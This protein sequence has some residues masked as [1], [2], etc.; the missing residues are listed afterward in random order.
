MGD[1]NTGLKKQFGVGD[2]NT[3]GADPADPDAGSDKQAQDFQAAFQQEQ[4]VI[5]GHLQYTAANAEAARH[6]PLAA[7]RDAMYAAFQSTLGKIDRKNPAKAQGSIDKVLAD[8]RA[9]TS[10]VAAFHEEAEKAKTEWESRQASYDEAVHHVE[11]LEA[12]EEPKAAALRGLM[13]GIRTQVNQRQYAQA[14]ATLDQLLP[15]LAP[16]YEEYLRQKEAKPQYE[17]QSAEQSARLDPL[18]AAQRPS[19]PMTAKAGEADTALADARAKAEARDWVAG[20]EQMQAVQTAVDALEQLTN[21]P[22]RAKFL[23]DIGTLDD[24]VQAPS[25]TA[26]HTQEADWAAIAALKEQI[27]PAGDSGDYACANSMIGQLR[28]KVDAFKTK[29]D[30]LEQQKQAYDTALAQVQ[31]RLDSASVSEQQYAKLQPMLADITSV[32]GQADASAQAEDFAAALASVNDLSTKLDALDQAK[33]EIDRQKQAYEEALAALKPRLDAASVSEPPYA[34]LQAQR[35]ELATAQTGMEAAAA[36][37]DYEQAQQQLESLTAK[38]EELEQA[39]AEID[40]LKQ[41]YEAALAA[42]KPRLDA[43]AG[44][45]PQYVKLQPQQAEVRTLQADAEAAAQAGEYEQATQK[46]DDLTAKL[47]TLDEARKAIDEQKQKFD[48]ALAALKPKLDAADKPGP[49][50][51]IESKRVEATQGKS[52]IDAAA[53]AFDYEAG[54]KAVQELEPKLDAYAEALKAY[55]AQKTEYDTTLKTLQPRLEKALALKNDKLKDKQGSLA[56]GQK[57]MEA[58]ALIGNFEEALKTAKD[59]ASQLDTFE[60]EAKVESAVSLGGEATIKEIEFL[61]TPIGVYAEAVAKVGGSVKFA[62]AAD[63]DPKDATKDQVQQSVLEKLDSVIRAGKCEISGGPKF[64]PKDKQLS[65]AINVTFS[66]EWGPLTFEFAPA[67]LSIASVDPKKGISGPKVSVVNAAITYK[68]DSMKLDVGGVSI[69]YGFAGSFQVE[70]SPNWVTIGEWVLK[71]LAIDTAEGVIAVDGAALASAAAAIALPAAAAAAIGYGMY[72]EA[73]NMRADSEAIATALSARKKATQ[74][75]ASYAKVLTGG[76]GGGDEGA[77][78]AEAQIAQL[79][80]Q[81]HG[82]REEV[83]AAVTQAQGGWQAIR[84]RELQKLK[85]RM[86]A[87][88]C[89]AFDEGHKGEFTLLERIGPDYGFRGSFRQMLRLV[90]YSDD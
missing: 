1:S 56:T 68:N 11:E 34:K 43:A 70:I 69:Q 2:P 61:K 42:L 76:H 62:P 35:D 52:A 67:E 39:K 15:K 21:D 90:L 51:T 83:I 40:K 82:T 66:C 79:M 88:A 77:Q 31:P 53:A 27:A 84:E 65:F 7:R 22:E 50:P 16:I 5:N 60:K 30:E 87:Q 49:T 38:V 58:A 23:A 78:H 19:Q 4:G 37:G 85:D 29:H 44:S 74:A 73:R 14:T 54:L 10:E 59:L 41:A 33:A 6:D 46:L 17:Q 47:D 86:Y 24:I 32:R 48:E 26:F 63:A 89:E 18:K 20:L 45:E 75:A 8:A 57:S 72:Q 25:G 71:Q 55:D 80:D 28:E 81:T 3:P 64:N 9:L 36:G 13:D 12:F